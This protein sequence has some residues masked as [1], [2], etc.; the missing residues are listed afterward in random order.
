MYKIIATCKSKFII[1]DQELLM[2]KHFRLLYS[3][4]SNKGRISDPFTIDLDI[5][6]DMNYSG[7]SVD[8]MTDGESYIRSIYVSHKYQ[9]VVHQ[10]VLDIKI[11]L[12]T[13]KFCSEEEKIC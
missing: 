11:K 12:N 13:N 4:C 3:E 10:I 9:R 8:R 6:R 5:K 2:N 1:K 7:K